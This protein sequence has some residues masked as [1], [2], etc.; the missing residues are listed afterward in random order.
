VNETPSAPE[1]L[2]ERLEQIALLALAFV[3]PLL[4]AP[5]NLLWLAYCALWLYNR[6]RSRDF[7]GRWDGWDTLIALWIASGHLAGLFAGLQDADWRS[8]ADLLR[9]ASVLWMLKRSRLDA[10]LYSRMLIALAAGTLVTLAWGYWGLLGTQQ[11]STLGLKSVGHVNH[12]AIYLAIVYGA[13]LLHA[14]SGWRTMTPAWRIGTA[15]ALVVFAA[16]LFVMQSRGAV[17]AA[18]VATVMLLGVHAVRTRRGVHAVAAG[19]ALAIALVFAVRPQVLEKHET[20]VSQGHVLAF[21]DGIWRTGID[22]WRAHPWF[23]VGMDN[24]GRIDS[25]ALER[26]SAA[27]GERFDLQRYALASHAHSLYVNTLAERGI[28]GL[29]ALIAVLAAW[30]F[31]LL[32]GI[33]PPDA[34]SIEWTAWGGAASAWLIS[35]IVGTV[36]TT[37]HHEHALASMLLLGA[38]LSLRRAAGARWRAC[39]SGASSRR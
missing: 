19:T 1:P 38:W 26:W 22:A 37:L 32:R 4:E 21:R 27:R 12:S 28:F 29:A 30:L 25:A 20:F 8:N 5:K 15:F 34:L 17:G 16:S 6:S 3:L 7:G 14:R 31:T 2:P 18:L 33:P 9:Y 13:L 10:R 24:F 11:R 23:G 35:V 36:N 39:G